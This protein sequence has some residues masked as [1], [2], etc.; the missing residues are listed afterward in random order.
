MI[1]K[2]GVWTRKLGFITEAIRATCGLCEATVASWEQRSCVRAA[3]KI[4]NSDSFIDC[5]NPWFTINVH[6]SIRIIPTKNL[7]QKTNHLSNK[8]R[9]SYRNALRSL[10][11]MHFNQSCP[12][13]PQPLP[14][15]EWFN[16]ARCSVPFRVCFIWKKQ[17]W[18]PSKHPKSKICLLSAL[19]SRLSLWGVQEL[20]VPWQ[21]IRTERNLSS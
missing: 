21:K 4:S 8:V 10:L 5:H 19:D 16:D 6:T 12:L 2:T 3:H 7:A 17:G 1:V 18:A 20:C 9:T 15:G 13:Q 14:P 11:Y